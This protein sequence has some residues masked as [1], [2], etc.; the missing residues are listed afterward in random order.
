MDSLDV[1]LKISKPVAVTFHFTTRSH[2]L[3][4][5][6]CKTR[7]PNATKRTFVLSHRISYSATS[8]S[9][10]P[11]QLDVDPWNA[12][13]RFESHCVQVC[14]CLCAH[15]SPSIC[16]KPSDVNN[17]PITAVNYTATFRMC[18]DWPLQDKGSDSKMAPIFNEWFKTKSGFMCV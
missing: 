1:V 4:Y 13:R 17:E 7:T 10:S 5:F 3:R 12:R 2:I 8:V 14:I 11:C 6:W 15:P 18:L 9:P 16:S